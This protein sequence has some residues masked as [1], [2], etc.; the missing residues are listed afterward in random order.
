MDLKTLSYFVTV[1]EELNISHAAK[2]L[3]MSQPPLSYQIKS[4]EQELNTTLFVRGKRS[5]QMTEA[6][7]LLY[8]R[9]KE[10]LDLSSKA[11]EEILSMAQGMKGTISLGLVEGTAPH[12]AGEWFTGFYRMYPNVRFRIMDG[13][14][15]DLVEK[16]RSGLI[17]MAVITS[18][19]DHMLL[20]SFPV[21]NEPMVAF[22]NSEHPLSATEGNS[23]SIRQLVGE[24][25]IVPSRRAL[26]EDIYRWF[27]SIKSEPNIICEMDNY[28]DAAALAG[29][30]MGISIFPQTSYI[31]NTSL[32]SKQIDGGT[33][34][35][36][37][38][39]VWQ[40]GRPLPSLEEHFIDFVKDCTAQHSLI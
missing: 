6:G 35:L 31:S 1:A 23:V 5:L 22:M 27:R 39:F 30:G 38:L 26:I 40:K 17:S 24:P 9:A 19:C 29:R 8:R 25:L 36:E 12:I 33:R 15:D 18:P 4:L 10:I 11:E 21:G 2:K 13:N 20:N 37:Y 7:Q 34:R 3:N 28:L 16:L 14:S 32:V